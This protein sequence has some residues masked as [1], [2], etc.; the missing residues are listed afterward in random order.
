MHMLRNKNSFLLQFLT[1]RFLGG[2]L[3]PCPP[4]RYGPVIKL[5]VKI[6]IPFRPVMS[7]IL[8]PK[9]EKWLIRCSYICVSLASMKLRRESLGG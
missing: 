3:P 8:E 1:L 6:N 4:A 5:K 7:R 9:V 2:Q